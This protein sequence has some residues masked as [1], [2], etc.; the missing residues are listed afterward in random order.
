M[1]RTGYKIREIKR[2]FGYNKKRNFIPKS[3]LKKNYLYL[4]GGDS[5][6]L[7]VVWVGSVSNRPIFEFQLF[8]LL[9]GSLLNY[10]LPKCSH[11]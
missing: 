6:M 3:F 8:Y 11:L 5:K 7:V 2:E 4:F 1:Q 10:S 9:I